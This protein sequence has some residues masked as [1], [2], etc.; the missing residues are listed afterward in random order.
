[1]NIDD[2]KREAINNNV[3]IVKD[4][5]LE[6]L[7]NVIKD[8]NY[9]SIL[10]LGSAVGYSAIQMALL[11]K[12]IHIDTLEK[13]IDMYNKACFN[14]K[15]LGLTNQIN[16][17]NMPI[18]EFKTDKVYDFIFIDAAKAQYEKYFDQ[19][20]DNLSLNGAVLFDNMCFHGMINDIDSI[21]NRNTRSLVKKIVKFRENMLNRD[22]FDIILNDII[23]D[24]YMLVTRR[25]DGL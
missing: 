19:F 18:E 1:M 23:G 8:N 21:K 9:C 5:T 10:E 3:P 4:D 24:G 17:I 16:I 11:N 22:G 6:V 2:I 12:N 25:K 15:E 20:L 13:N 14:V 7:L